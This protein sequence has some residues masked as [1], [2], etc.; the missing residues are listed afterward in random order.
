M[1]ASVVI[2]AYNAS[3]TL[4]VV[5]DA[6][7]KQDEPEFEVIVV[8][9]ASTDDTPKVAESFSDKLDLHVYSP[10][11]NLGRARARNYGVEK[12]SAEVVLL[13]DSDIE[14]VPSYVS[15]HL[16][17]HETEPR[18]V[19]VGVLRYPPYL[20][21]RALARYY[22]SRGGARIKPDEPLPGKA[23]VSCLASFRR[24]LFEEVGGFHPGFRIY[25][26][27]DLELGLKFQKSG[28]VLKY[29]RDAIGYHH[30]LRLLKE[31]MITLEKYGREGVPLVLE[32]HPDFAAEMRL[33]DLT[34]GANTIRAFFRRLVIKSVFYRPL[35][36]I[37]SLLQYR[38]LPSTLLT[39][40]HYCAYRRGFG[41]Y[42]HSS[43]QTASAQRNP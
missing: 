32:L 39:Y 29:L 41:S 19:G 38:R 35:L 25:G 17:L 3:K 37:A 12:S 7:T 22:S 24:S 13:L 33:D 10:P 26:G 34:T 23:F 14:A 16:A 4:G 27:E 2:P 9:D 43:R 31:V 18:A 6:L 20:A 28:A 21:K 42:L 5:L 1:K 36:E 30:H 15:A 8:D 40:L 11:E